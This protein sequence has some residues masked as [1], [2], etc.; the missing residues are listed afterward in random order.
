MNNRRLSQ[1]E[2]QKNY[3]A[4]QTCLHLPLQEKPSFLS[5]VGVT[6]V[7]ING[8]NLGS[9]NGKLNEA[10]SGPQRL[11]VGV[12]GTKNH[13]YLL[14]IFTKTFLTTYSKMAY[15]FM[16]RQRFKNL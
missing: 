16:Y 8:T 4:T 9:T 10:C 1:R 12:M 3:Q 5:A 14:K 6:I 11:G 13:T 15:I 7:C 2:Y